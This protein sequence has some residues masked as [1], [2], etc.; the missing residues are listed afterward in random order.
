[1]AYAS[2]SRYETVGRDRRQDVCDGSGS[3]ATMSA[4]MTERVDV[5]ISKLVDDFIMMLSKQLTEENVKDGRFLYRWE[6]RP[7]PEN[8]NALELFGY[9]EQIGLWE[10]GPNWNLHEIGD[11]LRRLERRDLLQKLKNFGEY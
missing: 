3:P 8:C 1:M 11:L 6:K 4:A 2:R 7:P 10:A 5:M 9:L